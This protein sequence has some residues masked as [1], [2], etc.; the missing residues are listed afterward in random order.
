[1]KKKF[2]TVFD[3]GTGGIWQY[4]YAESKEQIEQK[5]REITVLETPPDWWADRPMD[6]KRE[7]DIDGP[8]DDFMSR[9]VQ[10]KNR[11]DK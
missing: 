3:Y 10:T 8:L 11:S 2:L 7:Y 5:F 6:V 1:M 4:V 9:M